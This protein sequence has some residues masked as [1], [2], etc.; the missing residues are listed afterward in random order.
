[1][2]DLKR[3][4]KGD[5]LTLIPLNEYVTVMH[6]TLKG[7]G[8]NADEAT[9]FVE[10]DEGFPVAVPVAL[11][12]RYLTKEPPKKQPITGN[13]VTPKPGMIQRLFGPLM[14]DRKK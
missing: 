1:M 4:H 14:R 9:V 3:Y 11:Q 7:G 13:Q 10:T 8:V 6:N 2:S 12:D 5:V